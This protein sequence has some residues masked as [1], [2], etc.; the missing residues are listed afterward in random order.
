[1]ASEKWYRQLDAGIRFAVRLLHSRGIETCQ[2]CQGGRGHAYDHPTID[3]I[4]CADDASGFA[5]VAALQSHGLTVS[6][7][8]IVWPMKNGLPYEK[9]WRV[10]LL[11]PCPERANSKPMFVY[12]Y[13]AT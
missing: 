4:A 9:L 2:S 3:L 11:K 10:V 7:L 12:S 8:Q 6:E 1:M 5:A 13:E